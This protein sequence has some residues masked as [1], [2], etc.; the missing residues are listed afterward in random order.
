LVPD[1]RESVPFGDGL[2]DDGVAGVAANVERRI[3]ARNGPLLKKA[4][5]QCDE[6]SM[7]WSQFS[8]IFANFW[9]KNCVFLKNQSYDNI[10]SKF[11]FVSSQKRQFF[12]KYFV[13]NIFKI[14]TSVP[15]YAKFRDIFKSWA[16]FLL[17]K[18]A[19]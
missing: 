16:Q 6:G 15:D 5:Q 8:A 18:V 3:R 7:L 13:E 14:I 10:F 19:Q 17:P 2:V 1:G 9:R 11:A 4:A 12:A